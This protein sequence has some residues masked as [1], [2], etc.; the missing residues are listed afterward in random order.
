MCQVH[1]VITAHW[2]LGPPGIP[3]WSEVAQ[4]C[5][6]LCDPVDCNPPGSSVHGILQARILEWVTISSSRGSS[7]PRD[8][9]RDSRIASRRFYLW[10]TREVV[11][12]PVSSLYSSKPRPP[13]AGSPYL[14]PP[15]L[16]CFLLVVLTAIDTWHYIIHSCV[17]CC[18]P[19]PE[20]GQNFALLTI[21]FKYL[22]PGLA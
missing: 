6:T 1:S 13:P 12:I 15:N 22:E 9:T 3:K 19:P 18:S 16:L 5:P 21:D 7:R 10:A 17:S 11:S 14:Y 2:D 4:S 20:S 8:W